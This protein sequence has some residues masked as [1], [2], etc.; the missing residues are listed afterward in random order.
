N[1]RIGAAIESGTSVGVQRIS[2]EGGSRRQFRALKP[3]SGRSAAYDLFL[4]LSA[5]RLFIN[6]ES[7]LRPPGVRPPRFSFGA[8]LAVVLAD[9]IL[10]PRP[11]AGVVL[12]AE[13]RLAYFPRASIKPSSSAAIARAIR[14][15]SLFNSETIDCRSNSSLLLGHLP[16]PAR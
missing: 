1:E 8:A 7:F 10:E 9:P 5:Q 13:E 2:I 12:L 15:R 4:F 16:L 3:T 14:S 11:R 6:S